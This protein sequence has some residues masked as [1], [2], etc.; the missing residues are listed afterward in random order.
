MTQEVLEIEGMYLK[1][2]N[3]LLVRLRSSGMLFHVG[4]GFCWDRDQLCSTSHFPNNHYETLMINV[5]PIAQA[6]Y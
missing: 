1:E 2:A 4:R 3:V 6:Y 5:Q